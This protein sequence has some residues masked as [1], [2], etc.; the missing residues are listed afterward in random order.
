MFAASPASR[1]EVRTFPQQC[2]ISI[3]EPLVI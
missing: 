2:V 3:T 1:S